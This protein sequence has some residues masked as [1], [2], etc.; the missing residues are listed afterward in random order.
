MLEFE[1]WS[2]V[3]FCYGQLLT[4][5][6]SMQLGWLLAC[7]REGRKVSVKEHLIEK[8]QWDTLPEDKR[9]ASPKKSACDTPLDRRKK[10]IDLGTSQ[11]ESEIQEKKPQDTPTASRLSMGNAHTPVLSSQR[12]REIYEE[13]SKFKTPKNSAVSDVDS[14]GMPRIGSD[15]IAE[16]IRNIQES[17]HP[18]EVPEASFDERNSQALS[19]ESKLRGVQFHSSG[20]PQRTLEGNLVSFSPEQ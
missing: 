17:P 5:H 18:Y 15:R 20:I 11:M 14:P 12:M 10:P 19:G 7:A 6:E 2:D 4:L 16:M 8:K 13:A 1:S 3:R 9:K